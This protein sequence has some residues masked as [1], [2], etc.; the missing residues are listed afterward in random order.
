MANSYNPNTQDTA[1]LDDE[2]FYEVVDGKIVELAPMGAN[3]VWLASELVFY[4][5]S[6]ARQ[7]R[8]GRAVPEM[9]FDLAPA[10]PHKRRPDA[11]F[12]SYERWPQQR[13]VPRAD[14]WDVVPNLA[15]EVVSPSNSG[16]EIIGKVAEYFQAGVECVWVIYPL[17][18]QVYVYTSPTQVRILTRADELDG[19]PVLPQFRL[20]VA[21]LFEDLET[22]EPAE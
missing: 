15:V 14:A 4:L 20:P 13:I 16:N 19:A 5:M 6:F 21:A 17:Q 11:A 12:V 7:H 18:E 3:E 1:L 22:V 9:L 2:I 8:L 10:V